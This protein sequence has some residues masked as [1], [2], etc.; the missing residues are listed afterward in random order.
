MKGGEERRRGR[1]PY[2]HFCPLQALVYNTFAVMRRVA[3]VRQRCPDEALAG[4]PR[5]FFSWL[6]SEEN[7]RDN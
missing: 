4:S 2:W 3:R 6:F 5:R 7:L 1:V